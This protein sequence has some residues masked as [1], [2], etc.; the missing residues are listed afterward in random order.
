MLNPILVVR[1][2]IMV[3]FICVTIEGFLE[4]YKEGKWNLCHPIYSEECFLLDKTMVDVL[5]DLMDVFFPFVNV[6]NG[7][8]VNYFPFDKE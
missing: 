6:V 7:V 2:F 1:I 4:Q 8:F 5:K 3:I